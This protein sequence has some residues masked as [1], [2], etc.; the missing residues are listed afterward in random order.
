MLRYLSYA[1]YIIDYGEI[2]IYPTSVPKLL[3]DANYV[4]NFE[5]PYYLNYI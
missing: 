1:G 2:Y 5:N 4:K 3:T